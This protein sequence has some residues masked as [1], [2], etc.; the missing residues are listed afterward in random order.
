[1]NRTNI[2]LTDD[3]SR[4]TK[5]QNNEQVPSVAVAQCVTCQKAIPVICWCLQILGQEHVSPQ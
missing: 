1:M 3:V 2:A 5:N 4:F